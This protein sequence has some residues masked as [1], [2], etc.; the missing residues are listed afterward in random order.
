MRR[1]QLHDRPPSENG[2]AAMML[3]TEHSEYCRAGVCWHAGIVRRMVRRWFDRLTPYRVQEW[4]WRERPIPPEP[5]RTKEERQACEELRKIK[6]WI[7]TE[8]RRIHGVSD[9]AGRTH[10]WGSAGVGCYP[11]MDGRWSDEDGVGSWG[12]VVRMVEDAR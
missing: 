4:G 12:R 10:D 9:D 8:V 3:C 5:K 6:E 7:V 2:F 11:Q 1:V